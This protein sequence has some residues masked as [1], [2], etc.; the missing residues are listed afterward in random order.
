MYR[1]QAPP[2]P[3]SKR[4]PEGAPNATPKGI[5]GPC[6]AFDVNVDDE[7]FSNLAKWKRQFGDIY[8]VESVSRANPSFVLTN[9]AHIRHVL[10]SNSSNY[11]KGVGFERV[12]MLLGNGIIVSDGDFWRSQR[13]MM[14]PMFQRQVV[15]GLS[16]MMQ[17][18]NLRKLRDWQEKARQQQ[19]INITEEMSELALEVVL[20]ALFS[21]DLDTMIEEQAQNPFDILVKDFTRD[22]KFAMQFRSL[23][24]FVTNIMAN[25]RNENRIETDFLG[26]LMETRN[27]DT[28]EPLSDKAIVDEVMTIIVAG[29]ETT[30]GTPN[31]AW[32]LLSQDPAVAQTLRAEAD[33]LGHAPDFA[34]LQNL[35][36]TKQVV[37]EALRLYPPVWLFSRKA[38]AADRLGDYYLPPEADVFICP[39]L[40]HRDP[41][42][43]QEPDI[44]RPQRFA[45]NAEPPANRHAFIPF[46]LGSR[47]CVGE[48]FSLVDM[49][50]HLATIA[51]HLHLE[52]V[53]ENPV[54]VQPHINLRTR[55]DLYMQPIP[56]SSLPD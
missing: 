34:D 51:Q 2:N 50:L 18:C 6:D 10:V 16:A 25:R 46:S 26:M 40:L 28:A 11:N 24:R 37:E 42:I 33:A 14:Q 4:T 15:A 19:R 23:T 45:K 7:T 54:E 17:Q 3:D 47:R 20:R 38:I 43:W 9:P 32:Y 55:F 31:W 56:R 30:A 8:R 49:Q 35:V 48:F 1:N 39:Y 44:F 41:D 29:H 27:K 52:F 36:Y 5:E 13:R 21:S 53:A 22:L 12:K